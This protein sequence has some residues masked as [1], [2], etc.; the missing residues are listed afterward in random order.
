MLWDGKKKKGKK[1]G[2]GKGEE[3]AAFECRICGHI[4]YGE[5]HGHNGVMGPGG[6]SW[7]KHCYCK[8]CGVMFV[9]PEMF[10]IAGKKQ[11]A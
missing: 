4:E 7:R 3:K 5:A 1:K 6:R 8:G 9:S 11:E 10:S 2:K